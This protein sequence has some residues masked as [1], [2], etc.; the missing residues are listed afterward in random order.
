MTV[1]QPDF[2]KPD[3]LFST[4]EAIL[5][6][7]QRALDQFGDAT[8][9]IDSYVS[10][11]EPPAD[12]FAG[13][14][15]VVTDRGVWPI[16]TLAAEGSARLMTT[17]G[18]WVD[19]RVRSFGV[20][21]LRA[22]TIK[23]HGRSKTLYATPRHRWIA[24]D[25]SEVLTDDLRP[26][27]RLAIETGDRTEQYDE[28]AIG[29]G[30]VYGDGSATWVGPNGCTSTHVILYGKKQVLDKWLPSDAPRTD[31]SKGDMPGI[32]VGKLPGDWK[33]LPDLDRPKEWL[34]GWLMGYIA[35]D[36]STSGNSVRLASV[37]L[38]DMERVREMCYVLGIG[39]SQVWTQWR[40][41]AFGKGYLHAISLTLSTLPA[42][43][44][45]REDQRVQAGG[46]DRRMA[47]WVVES[48]DE[49]E[50]V[51]EVFCAT[52]PGTAAFVLEDNLLVG[53]CCNL[54]TVYVND[55]GPDAKSLGLE[56]R[57]ATPTQ[58]PMFNETRFTVG[59]WESC[60]PVVDASGGRIALPEPT[61]LHE[62]NRVIYR[63]G[64]AIFTGVNLDYR[65]GDLFLNPRQCPRLTFGKLRPLNQGG[66]AGWTFDIVGTLDG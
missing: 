27:L 53:N 18:A 39:T 17:G 3:P 64:F 11:A 7:A 58:V 29:A 62:I 5:S 37:K 47:A 14:T 33:E 40:E 50:R 54:L 34:L 13:E 2:T 25:G 4:A 32:R 56:A 26:G 61:K 59:L 42:G 43:F 44:F 15:R 49:T 21:E 1:T 46:S 66:C 31:G 6:S 19:A 24:A 28:A 55:Y 48:V 16:A 30:I 10:L 63:H 22:V 8:K 35:T 38:E 60:Y 41:S 51:E 9:S 12:C 20:R 52:V 36:G 45:I 23:R 57:S 65:R